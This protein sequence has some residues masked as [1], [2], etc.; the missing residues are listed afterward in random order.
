MEG[1][2]FCA[3]M[4]HENTVTPTLSGYR[5]IYSS[6]I[7]T[8]YIS[9]HA[10]RFT[11]IRAARYNRFKLQIYDTFK[12]AEMSQVVILTIIMYLK[13]LRSSRCLLG[14]YNFYYKFFHDFKNIFVV[15]FLSSLGYIDGNNRMLRHIKRF[16][17]LL[18]RRSMRFDCD[19]G[20]HAVVKAR[21]KYKKS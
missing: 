18:D 8:T 3:F 10:R 19:L 13:F 4:F 6:H 7:I 2:H 9:I 14:R 12:D 16:I 1:E 17:Y 15:I 20:R 5:K 21:Y 11:N